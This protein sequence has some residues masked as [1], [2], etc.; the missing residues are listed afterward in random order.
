MASIHYVH[1]YLITNLN[2]RL[3]SDQS[4]AID[5][6][7]EFLLNWKN[8]C[9]FLLKGYA[10]TGKT[11][12]LGTLVR[13]LRE[14]SVACVLLAPT[15]R[16]AKVLSSA[17]GFQSSTIHREIYAIA[18][19]NDGTPTYKLRE[20]KRT[21]TLFVVDEA[22]I[23]G[24]GIDNSPSHRHG[25]LLRD[26]VEYIRGGRHCK[27]L[28]SGDE[29]QLPPIGENESPA[30]QPSILENYFGKVFQATL[31]EVLRQDKESGVLHF[32]TQLRGLIENYNGGMPRFDT[33]LYH[34]F[35]ATRTNRLMEM[36]EES[37][38]TVGLEETIVLCRSN[39]R[40][41][42]INAAIRTSAF[43]YEEPL[44]GG[45]RVFA[46]KNSYRWTK[47]IK[48]IPFIANG[49]MLR[50]HRVY[51]TTSVE[52]FTFVDIDFTLEEYPGLE[53][54]ATAMLNALQ[55]PSAALPKAEQRAFY[56]MRVETL[57][58]TLGAEFSP[59]AVADDPLLTALQLKHGYALTC[60]KSQG[61]Q[62]AHV[63][64]DVELFSTTARDLFFLRWLYTA[65]S[66]ATQRLVL[67][68]PPQELLTPESYATL[69]DDEY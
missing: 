4:R 69:A 61:G 7:I 41:A 2:D 59:R 25:G 18:E 60:H 55:S 15:G 27:L 26:L 16:A 28:L 38:R 40:A 52:N 63:Y 20:N 24:A 33:L 50:L 23:I 22:S 65:I 56:N 62:W 11:T 21:N 6:L 68:S 34:D 43:G 47:R 39:R 48:E 53:I 17:T 19:R 46:C 12:L 30:L 32:A 29:A 54:T 14:Q 3:T 67:I 49:D 42:L 5:T 45:D 44:A 51:N 13:A 58:E 31:R 36:I 66:R 35:S 37:Y 10:G 9:C 1:K 8:D 64:L 57:K